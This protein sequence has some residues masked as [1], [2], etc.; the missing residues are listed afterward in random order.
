MYLPDTNRKKCYSEMYSI[1]L[2]VTE[3]FIKLFQFLTSRIPDCQ[4]FVFYDEEKLNNSCYVSF[5]NKLQ[6]KMFPIDY[7]FYEI[8][9]TWDL[10][11]Y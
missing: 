4:T 7:F 9:I 10:H 1:R 3:G 5:F 8:K 11:Q 2:I 6:I